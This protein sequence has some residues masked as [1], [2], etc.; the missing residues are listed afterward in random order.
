[1]ANKENNNKKNSEIMKT[2]I[3]TL[4][5]WFFIFFIYVSAGGNI[6]ATNAIEGEQEKATYYNPEKV[7][8]ST[9]K[10]ALDNGEIDT[11]YIDAEKMEIRYTVL[12]DNTKAMSLEDRN[13]VKDVEKSWYY[14]DYPGDEGTFRNEASLGDAQVQA[15]S[16][17]FP[18]NAA[19]IALFL[20]L[21]F[22]VLFIFIMYR[23][24]SKNGMNKMFG[25]NDTGI[26]EPNDRADASFDDIIG[27]DEAIRDIK[28][29]LEIMQDASNHKDL[30]VKPPRGI[31]LIGPPGTG[32]TMIAKACAKEAG[33]NFKYVNS[34]KIIDRFVGQGANAIRNTFKEAKKAE[35]CILFFDEIDSIGTKRSAGYGAD[36]EYKQT[37][38][39]LLQELDGFST[40]S[41]IFVMAAT[42]MFDSLDPALVRP[43]RFDRK[44]TITPPRNIET[45][46]QLLEHYLKGCHRANDVN[47][48]TIAR[49]LSG[50][51][52]A[53]IA[54]IC[55][56]AK[57]IAIQHKESVIRQEY[58][59]EAMDKAFFKGNRTK[60]TQEKDREI[61]A[62]HESGH[63]IS[64]LINKLPIARISVIPSTSGVGGMVVNSDKDS[65][66]A[67]KGEYIARIKS[68][69]AGR[70]AEEL[71]Y[72]KENIT[73]G[74]SNDIQVATQAIDEYINKFAFDGKESLLF[75]DKEK[76]VGGFNSGYD[77]DTYDRMNAIAKK[78]YDEA[79]VELEEN[80]DILK[81]LATRLL[82]K[83]TMDKEEV[84]EFFKAAKE[85]Q[86]KKGKKTPSRLEK[87]DE[88]AFKEVSEEDKGEISKEVKEDK[89]EMSKEVKE[90]KVEIEV[91]SHSS[92]SDSERILQL[93]KKILELENELK[94]A[95]NHKK[96]ESPL[97]KLLGL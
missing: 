56:E 89:G 36:S 82:E 86:A 2:I 34:S 55:N 37:L 9:Y 47:L 90:D 93:E 8:Y 64:M 1:M 73:T 41:K 68:L 11:V 87:V 26:S 24:M 84:E 46:K 88:D 96:K 19:T 43:G 78:Y 92:N 51:T 49:Q 25:I 62:Y 76:S 74:A 14:L 38:N 18:V 85:E 63:A 70:I 94:Q 15:R 12:D 67:T 22:P 6:K 21:L 77:R 79:K 80:L 60:N 69:Y 30:D 4:V 52:G 97:A 42:N 32:K 35:P 39:A 13:K 10:E 48:D 20:N 50:M 59:E 91:S 40:S 5:L 7:T 57:L 31:L 27:H 3:N 29:T 45:R 53:D 83:E 44:I 28:Q 65:M 71:I 17:A 95:K 16:W 23:M 54:Q 66:F 72:G 81:A 58:L 75:L 61:V 33:L